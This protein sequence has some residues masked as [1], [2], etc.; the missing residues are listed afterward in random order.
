MSR[1]PPPGRHS[2][3]RWPTTWSIGAGR[4]PPARPANPPEP[5]NPKRRCAMNYHGNPCWYELGTGDLDAAAGFY[6]R[7]L[8]WQVVDSGMEGFDYRLARSDGDM[9]AGL[10]SIADQQGDP[11][12][13]WLI[14]FAVDDCDG[15]AAEVEA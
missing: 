4:T 9:V 12:P 14:Y 6:G 13:N 5:R 2:K 11:S 3:E 8:G 7:I 10:M 1:A 15:T